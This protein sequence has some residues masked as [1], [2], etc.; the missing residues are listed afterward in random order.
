[1]C[2]IVYHNSFH[3]YST[4]N[5]IV[6]RISRCPATVIQKS[7]NFIPGQY[8]HNHPCNPSALLKTRVR[9]EVLQK[10]DSN[11]EQSFPAIAEQAF[12]A[13]RTPHAHQLWNLD[14][15][16]R[17]R[18]RKRQRLMPFYS[19]IPFNNHLVMS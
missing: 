6:L 2:K 3:I 19:S 7:E 12:Q 4:F 1:M 5:F 8:E 16:V 14:D 13:F 11:A 15:D 17:A 18:Q 9:V 10:C